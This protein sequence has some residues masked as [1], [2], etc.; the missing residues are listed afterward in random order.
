[1]VGD[2]EVAHRQLAD[3]VERREGASSLRSMRQPLRV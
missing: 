3:A 2:V 1:M